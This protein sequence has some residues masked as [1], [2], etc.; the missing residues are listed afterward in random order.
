MAARGLL[1][2]A[3]HD[4]GPVLGKQRVEP[5]E[6]ANKVNKVEKLEWS[7]RR[8]RAARPPL[9]SYR[10]RLIETSLRCERALSLSLTPDSTRPLAERKTDSARLIAARCERKS[11]QP[12]P[13]RRQQLA[14]VRA[15]RC[16]RADL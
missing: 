2:P 12:K 3:L 1:Q 15:C 9:S 4:A 11:Q 14:R 16:H 13:S 7:A 6:P 8:P 5:R 10:R